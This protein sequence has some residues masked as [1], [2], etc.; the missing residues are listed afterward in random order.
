MIKVVSKDSNY[1]IN[2]PES[3]NEIK[4]EH[5]E[6]ILANVK[7]PK[8]YAIVALAFR[9]TLFDFATAVNK[10]MNND[11]SVTPILMYIDEADKE[12]VRANVGDKV[13]VTRSSLERGV[14]LNLPV[15]ISSV[16]AAGYIQDHRDTYLDIIKFANK[17]AKDNIYLLEFKI[18]PVTEISASIDMTKELFDP[19]ITIE[20]NTQLN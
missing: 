3:I 19:Y 8:H 16:N 2:F 15:A 18:V 4:V 9:T 6:A 5:F 13:V 10:Q 11:V 1:G 17:N 14:H 20:D 7:I 12:N